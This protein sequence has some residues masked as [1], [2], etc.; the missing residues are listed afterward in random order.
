MQEIFLLGHI[1]SI[2][3]A[4]LSSSVPQYPQNVSVSVIRFMKPKVQIVYNPF[5]RSTVAVVHPPLVLEQPMIQPT[6]FFVVTSDHA[7]KLDLVGLAESK[8]SRN[9]SVF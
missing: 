9:C 2:S 7:I 1:L 8:I 5:L 3:E 4:N 6:N